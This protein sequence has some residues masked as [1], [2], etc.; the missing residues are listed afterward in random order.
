MKQKIRKNPEACW[1]FWVLF[2]FLIWRMFSLNVLDSS[3][4]LILYIIYMFCLSIFKYK[5][6]NFRLE[7]LEIKKFKIRTYINNK[8]RLW[9][10]EKKYDVINIFPWPRILKEWFNPSYTFLK[11]ISKRNE[12][13]NWISK[14]IAWVTINN[15]KQVDRIKLEWVIIIVIYLIRIWKDTYSDFDQSYLVSG[16]KTLN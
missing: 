7:W 6:R 10:L 15:H 11:N 14:F 2:F 3:S 12:S 16:F 4:S 13:K 8:E 5:V 9:F 1:T